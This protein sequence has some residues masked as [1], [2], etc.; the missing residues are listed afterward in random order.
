M[1]R[2]TTINTA[3]TASAGGALR[4]LLVTPRYFPFMGGVETHVFEVARRLAGL[5]IAATV[6]TTDPTGTLAPEE[7]SA[8]GVRIRRVP[9]WP[10]R[11][12]YYLAPQIY[13]AV[14][15]GDWD[16]VHCQSY[17]TLVAPLAML[18]AHR[19]DIPYVVSF[20]SGG[21]S[22]PLRNALRRPQRVL[23]RPLLARASRLVAV[24]QFEADFFQ[25]ALRLPRE[26]FA[27]VPNGA[28]LPRLAAAVPSRPASRPLILSVGRLERYKGHQRVV[29]A[30]PGVLR[31]F[32]AAELRI[33]GG[34]PYRPELERLA[35]RLGVAQRVTIG[36]LDPTQR[37]AM[38]ALVAGASLV[39][40]LSDYEAHPIAALEAIGLG[41]PTLV[42][43]GSGL[44]ELAQRGFAT[45]I[46]LHSPS[47]AVAAAI[48]AALEQPRPLAP[49][50]LPSWDDCTAELAALYRATA[51]RSPCAS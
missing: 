30:M 40:L 6:L 42:A 49:I 18:A 35:Q 27:V 28:E 9:A 16:V 45:A 44:R 11:E 23:L 51:R 46:P 39:T 43:D 48:V 37:G 10:K 38:A 25:P 1:L 21:H 50:A 26:R 8:D 7:T 19:S 31:R 33:V 14:A 4:V 41:R 20:H 17:Q 13:G 36:A 34:G 32:P 12:D 24:S 2:R 29:A 5:G 15:H 3:Q 22:S 47:A